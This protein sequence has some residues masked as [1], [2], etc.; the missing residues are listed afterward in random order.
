ME[1]SA[2]AL[3]TKLDA[4]DAFTTKIVP[5]LQD[6]SKKVAT[7]KANLEKV[8]E[9]WK[10]F[11]AFFGYPK[12][13]QDKKTEEFFGEFVVFWETFKTMAEEKRKMHE[14]EAEI[15]KKRKEKEE[16]DAEKAVAA[17]AKG[18][19]KKAPGKLGKAKGGED[20]MAAM[21]NSMKKKKGEPEPAAE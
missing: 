14:K 10:G 8:D 16:K 2:E 17:A 18:A 7:L 13:D 6:A 15:E 5:F 20:A 12:K 11:F 4:Q 19:P 3:R 1:K 9:E 21:V